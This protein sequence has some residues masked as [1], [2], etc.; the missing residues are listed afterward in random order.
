MTTQ[1]TVFA[2]ALL[3]FAASVPA[4]GTALN[5]NLDHVTMTGADATAVEF[6]GTITNTTASTIYLNGD[7]YTIVGLPSGAMDDSPFLAD[8]PLTLAGGTSTLDIG[9]FTI[10]IPNGFAT[11]LYNGS[12]FN[13]LGGTGGSGDQNLEGTATFNVNVQNGAATPEPS[14]FLLSSGGLLG[15]GIVMLWH[16]RQGQR[17]LNRHS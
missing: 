11:G 7:S 14:T 3:S 13:I 5:I 9:L 15:F 2:L 4:M 12:S 6:F 8:A 16:R 10:D 17:T 1:K